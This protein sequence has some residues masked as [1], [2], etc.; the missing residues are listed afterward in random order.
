MSA[1]A[2]CTIVS[3]NYIPFARV[4]ADSFHRH[5]P[6]G[7]FFVLLV[8]RNEGRID[9]EKEP[10][11]LIEAEELQN[12]PDRD[13]FLFKY[14]LLEA[15]TAV[16]PYFLQHL[17]ERYG[18]EDLVYFD[19]DILITGSLAELAQ[20]LERHS[21]V[22]TP[23]LTEGIDDGAHP[24]ELAVLQ[25]GAYNLGFLALRRTEVTERL[26][27]W[28]Q[29][30]LYD[31]CLV[32]IE[33]GLFVDQKWMDLVPGIFKD[34]HILTD[35]G[36]NVAYWNLHDRRITVPSGAL[37]G[38]LTVAGEEVR[39]N[40]RP[41]VFFH[42][43]G[44]D[45]DN[46]RP[47]SKHQ[48]RY[49][50]A[51]IGDAAQLYRCYRDLVLE[52]GYRAAKPWPYAFGFFDNGVAIPDAARTIYLRLGKKK[53]F[54]NPFE[55]AGKNSFFQYLNSCRRPSKE[56]SL[57]CLLGHLYEQRGDLVQIFPDVDGRD[58]LDFCAWLLD[59]GRHELKLDEAFLIGLERDTRATLFTVAGFKRRVRNRLK[60]VYHSEAGQKARQTSQRVLGRE[61]YQELRKKLRGPR[62]ASATAR[63]AG[64][65][66]LPLPPTVESFGVNLVGYFQAE[67]GMGEVARSLARAF[68]TTDV[69][70]SLH[71]LDLNVLARNDDDSFEASGSDFP[72]DLN[73]FMV[74]A[75]Q[76]LP[77]FEHLGPEVFS[78]RFNAGFWLWE[79]ESFPERW[80]GA[81][82][83]LHEVWTP[84]SFCVDSISGAAPVPVRRVPL[85]VEAK[86]EARFDRQHFDLPEDPFVF[87]FM[88]NFLS[89]V[90][91]KNPLALIRAFKEAFGDD[92]SALLV[93]KTAQSDFAQGSAERI[94][95]EIGAAK[96]VRVL[97]GYLDRS[98]ITALTA[99]SDA[100][101]SLHRSEGFG[102]TLAEAMLLGKPVVATPYSGNADFFDLNNGFPVRYELVEL[103]E[104]AGPYP[105]GT[106]WA[107][108]DV[109]HA[110][111]LMRR[112]YERREE[113]RPLLERARRDVEEK[114]S[115]ASV[116]RELERRVREAVLRVE[117]GRRSL[118]R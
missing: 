88:F 27:P 98:E 89:Y 29:D 51:D 72:Y 65:Y 63:P 81:F 79:L 93:F 86:V 71:S 94:R 16:K 77:V 83:L 2:A 85:P 61:R 18:L 30:R 43:S 78:G 21:I 4:L 20:L 108:P 90:E 25:A 105:A 115:Y 48:D 103:A 109:G 75:D 26:L 91:R 19:P 76:V 45:L 50:L 9:P 14:T 62:G 111:E 23:H 5:H 66:V 69:P 100:Y 84:S 38:K 8:D 99:I 116:G 87:L 107:E 112:V 32:S 104:D 52:A 54:G 67:T 102:L 49:T 17:F 64:G 22:L 96:N 95:Q 28:W 73:L 31:R 13:G 59:F 6:G 3:K 46:L 24:D 11:T 101:V 34:V 113:D 58:Y 36:Y 74:N 1:L 56:T 92:D 35:P 118:L 15:N 7:R 106:R 53:R 97:D 80:R 42:F 57:T 70:V 60:R 10:F 47:V 44:I 39:S 68:E 114:L 37:M 33:E 117:R 40:E 41:L 55:T 82:D 12:I 110:A